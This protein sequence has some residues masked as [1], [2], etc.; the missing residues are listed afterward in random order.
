MMVSN[1]L[2]CIAIMLVFY[3][4]RIRIDDLECYI[5]FLEN[6]INQLKLTKEV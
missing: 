5:E 4:C 2:N 1:I 3:Y 6:D